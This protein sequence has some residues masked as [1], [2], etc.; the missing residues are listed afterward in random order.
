[1]FQDDTLSNYVFA[2]IAQ[3]FWQ[4]EQLGLLDEF[5]PLF[6]PAATALAD[7]RGPAIA[8]A[9]GRYAFPLPVVSDVSLQ[10]GRKA[11]TDPAV[12]T[13]LHRA[14]TDRL[15]DLAR[16]LRVRSVHGG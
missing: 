9:I 11:L 15:D 13:A 7:R 5:V 16:T 3:G 4:P 1:M 12:T 8:D 10:H 6:Y 2:A 14:F